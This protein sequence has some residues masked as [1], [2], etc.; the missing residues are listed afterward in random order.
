MAY[1]LVMANLN[2]YP[3]ASRSPSRRGEEESHYGRPE[4]RKHKPD[5]QM[6]A[7]QCR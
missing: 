6:E 7:R 4:Y 5:D 3:A 2:E 1:D